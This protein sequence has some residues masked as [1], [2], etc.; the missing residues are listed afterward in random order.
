M[1]IPIR[2]PLGV[3][4]SA[5]NNN[6]NKSNILAHQHNGENQKENIFLNTPG[7]QQIA[8]INMTPLKSITNGSLNGAGPAMTTKK[9]P[10]QPAQTPR[11][12][13]TDITNVGSQK[14]TNIPTGKQQLQPVQQQLKSA[15][16]ETTKSK[17]VQIV[18]DDIPDIEYAYPTP[19][20]L[21]DQLPPPIPLYQIGQSEFVFS[22]MKRD[23]YTDMMRTKPKKKPLEQE[24]I[25]PPP[26]HD[27]FAVE[28]FRPF[29]LEF[30][31]VP[32]AV[33]EFEVSGDDG[34]SF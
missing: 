7:K 4:R 13:L 1:E 12:G 16:K 2:T 30:E 22:A 21:Q 11:K 27:D 10:L 25:A 14:V 23:I 5:L 18:E 33:G 32:I 29:D 8:N 6:I 20:H 9:T 19:K 34:F 3:R 31:Q 15:K 26:V 17:R 24:V 28:E